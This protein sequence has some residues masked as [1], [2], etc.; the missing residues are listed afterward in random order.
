MRKN[1]EYTLVL[2]DMDGTLLNGRTI[3]SISEKKGLKDTVLSLLQSTKE[4]Y[5]VSL[6]IARLLKG[7]D[8]RELLQ[9]FRMIPLQDH[10][11][12]VLKKLRE[13]NVKTAIVTDSYQ[14]LADDL[15]QRLQ[16]DYAFANN[17]IINEHI[18]TGDLQ[19]HNHA[20]Q[21]N[22]DGKLYSI[23]KGSVLDSLCDKLHF[24]P[25]QCI[26]VGDGFVDI[27]MIKKSGVGI[28]YNAP[29]EVRNH[30]DIVSDDLRVILNYIKM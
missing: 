1:Q 14:F 10:V 2:F 3:L 26:A 4:P 6:E 9:I 7:F 22:D 23:C 12:D 5:D 24:R 27:D 17:I 30:A 29:L 25:E 13:Q 19:P 15:R 11:K 8:C 16:I 21:R 28:A 20:R 18:I